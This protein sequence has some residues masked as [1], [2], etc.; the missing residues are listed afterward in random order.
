MMGVQ[1]GEINPQ[2]IISACKKGAYIINGY[3]MALIG[4]S[5]N[6]VPIYDFYKL[7]KVTMDNYGMSVEE[8]RKYV[9]KELVRTL[10]SNKDKGPIINYG[11]LGGD[12]VGKNGTEAGIPAEAMAK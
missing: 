8:A 3:N 11:Y 2:V 5:D 9:D 1:T 12:Y 6:G 4:V 7:V 10:P